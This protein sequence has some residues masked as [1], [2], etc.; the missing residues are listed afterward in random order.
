MKLSQSWVDHEGKYSLLVIVNDQY[1]YM[2][3][4]DNG[5]SDKRS[6]FLDY[7]KALTSFELFE[8]IKNEVKTRG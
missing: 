4:T 3:F 6:L 8:L 2:E 5:L 1:N 7:N